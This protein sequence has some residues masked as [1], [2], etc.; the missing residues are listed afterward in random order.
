MPR[1][2]AEELWGYMGKTM[3]YASSTI[4]SSDLGVYAA[5]DAALA[6]RIAAETG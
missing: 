1:Y 5:R 6:Q 4:D 3:L 2:H